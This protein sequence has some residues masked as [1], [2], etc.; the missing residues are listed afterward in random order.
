M[1]GCHATAGE[2]LPVTKGSHPFGGAQFQLRPQN[3]RREGYVEEEYLVSGEANVY[4]W[5]APGAAEVRTAGA[6]YTTRILVRRPRKAK[7][8]SGNV[9]VEMLNPSNLFDLNIGWAWRTRSS[10]GAAT[11]G[12]GSRRSRSPSTP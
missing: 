5:P 7:H 4:T 11:R 12:S 9:I 3:L 8:S 1:A 2:R 10:C 6:E